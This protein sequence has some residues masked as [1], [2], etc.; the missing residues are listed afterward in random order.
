MKMKFE[1][2]QNEQGLVLVELAA[3]K[4]NLEK[5]RK[6]I[7]WKLEQEFLNEEPVKLDGS[8]DTKNYKETRR[9]KRERLNHEKW[10]AKVSE[11]S[12]MSFE[13]LSKQN[14]KPLEMQEALL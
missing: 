9:D 12:G 5:T 10:M 13:E 4:E 7:E 11:A 14:L 2:M 8:Q 1:Q 3:N 6:E